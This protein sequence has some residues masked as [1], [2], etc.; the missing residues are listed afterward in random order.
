M[1]NVLRFLTNITPPDALVEVT[2]HHTQ[3]LLFMPWEQVCRQHLP[4]K[5]IALVLRNQKKHIYLRSKTFAEPRKKEQVWGLDMT[6]VLAGEARL[7]AAIR[8]GREITGIKDIKPLELVTLRW[9]QAP[10][11]EVN[12]FHFK[13][14]GALPPLLVEDESFLLLDADE[15]AGLLETAPEALAP[16]VRLAAGSERLF[17]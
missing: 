16:E 12:F 9:E 13:M 5:I 6:A 10:Q 7:S 17:S 14:P 15:V 11:I 2:D 3:P 8:A 1:D 4:C